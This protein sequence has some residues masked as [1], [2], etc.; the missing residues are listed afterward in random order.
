M[1]NTFRQESYKWF[2]TPKNI[3]YRR[4]RMAVNSDLYEENIIPS[5]P[6]RNIY[7]PNSYDDLSI[8][9]L[10]ENKK[11]SNHKKQKIYLR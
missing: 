9:S 6:N 3:N 4:N 8:S 1:S 10:N 5:K 2:R 11:V 7:I